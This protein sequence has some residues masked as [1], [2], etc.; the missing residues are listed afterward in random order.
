MGDFLGCARILAGENVYQGLNH[1]FIAS[2]PEVK[3]PS[4]V[5]EYRPITLC[6][7]LYKLISNVL[8][9][10][11]KRVLPG[12]ISANQSTFMPGRL[13][14]ENIIVVYEL[15]HSMKLNK[16]GR[17]GSITMKLDMSK[18]YDRVE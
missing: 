6:K 16:R 3:S 18:P 10:K 14:I 9:N 17:K 4:F 13:I 1:T 2:I 12:I 7:I 5:K 11:I 15:M 8:A